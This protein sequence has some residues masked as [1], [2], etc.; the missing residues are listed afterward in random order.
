[1]EVG[2]SRQAKLPAQVGQ[3]ACPYN[4]S[5]GHPTRDQIG[6]TDYMD[7]LVTPPTWGPL[8]PRKQALTR[9]LLEQA[10]R[11]KANLMTKE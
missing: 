6:M 11:I 10:I 5:Y 1:M 2:D 4:L 8:P 7:R 9:T 3:P